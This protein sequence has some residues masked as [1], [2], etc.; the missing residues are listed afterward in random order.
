[1]YI[2][3]FIYIYLPVLLSIIVLNCYLDIIVN[4]GGPSMIFRE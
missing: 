1:M 3:I 4:E 2:Y